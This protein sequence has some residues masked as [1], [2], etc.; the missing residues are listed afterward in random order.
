MVNFQYIPYTLIAVGLINAVY[1][2]GDPNSVTISYLLI[3]F[4]AVLF[5]GSRNQSV[6]RVLA[7][8]PV[9]ILTLLAAASLI[10]ITIFA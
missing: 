10:A 6:S 7:K 8:K 1:R 4:G 2:N 3:L 5:V 9:R